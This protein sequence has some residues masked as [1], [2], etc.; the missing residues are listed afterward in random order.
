MDL[1][2]Y[3]E[4]VLAMPFMTQLPP[5]IQERVAD[6][7][8]QVVRP[9]TVKCDELLY[10]QGAEDEDTG[11]LL[12]EGRVEIIKEGSEPVHCQAPTVL[13]EMKQFNPN[14]QRTAT[15]KVI[16]DAVVL[17]FYWHDFVVAARE[18]FSDEEQAALKKAITDLANLRFLDWEV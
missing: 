9:M 12:I 1:S 16:R 10:S 5:E 13:G 6:V 15:V 4:D 3:R 17:S 18:V 2:K 7:F 14:T 11:C 8:F